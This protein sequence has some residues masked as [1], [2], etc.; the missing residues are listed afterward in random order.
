MTEYANLHFA[1]ETIR[2]SKSDGPRVMV[3]GPNDSGK[4]SLVKILTAYAVR[5]GRT[6]VVV[7]TD[8]AEGMLSLP[9]SLSAT[10]MSTLMDVEDGWGS[11]PTSGPSMTP[12]K[13][14]LAYWLGLQSPEDDPKL[15]KPVC[16]R[17][18]LAVT[19][20]VD[21]DEDVKKAGI[22]IDTS[23][24]VSA[25]KNGYEIISH[26]ASEFAG[27]CNLSLRISSIILIYYSKHHNNHRF[28]AP[29]VRPL[30]PLHPTK[31]HGPQAFQ[32]W[33]LHRARQHIH[34]RLSPT[35]DL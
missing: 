25:G 20:R 19:G 32:V 30:P 28:R 14:P 9:G 15:F 35:T 31:R 11:S 18:A 26:I 17:L 33:W 24:A 3:V 29:P 22:I 4:T 34:G 10:V 1:L 21:E 6:P 13:L 16:S 7:N 27:M 12:V 2:N 23:G 8:P 5:M